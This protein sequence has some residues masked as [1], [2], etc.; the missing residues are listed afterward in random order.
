MMQAVKENQIA[1]L[2]A[3]IKLLESSYSVRLALKA[4]GL[5][6]AMELQLAELWKLD[7][8]GRDL[9]AVGITEETLDELVNSTFP[10]GGDAP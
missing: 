9:S 10:E 1:A 5:R 6:E 7:R 2:A 3:E 8:E 4:R